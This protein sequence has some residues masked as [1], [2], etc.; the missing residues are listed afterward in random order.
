MTA[1]PIIYEGA[2]E[3]TLTPGP[4]PAGPGF[5][6]GK[7]PLTFPPTMSKRY[8]LTIQHICTWEKAVGM[9][10]RGRAASGGMG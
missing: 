6:S 4:A 1:P 7:M 8:E 2:G 5:Q 10:R 9:G 3:W